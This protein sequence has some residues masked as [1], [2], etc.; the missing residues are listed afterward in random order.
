MKQDIKRLIT[1]TAI[2][3]SSLFLIDALVGYIGEKSLAKLPDYGDELCKSNYRLNRVKTD[4]I[5]VGS[6]RARHNYHTSILADSVNSLLG[7]NFT[8]YNTG[9]GGHFVDCNACT[10][11]SII[12]RHTPKLIIFEVNIQELINKN[13][14]KRIRKYEALYKNNTTVKDYL[15]R[16][17]WIERIRVR[18]NMYRFNSKTIVLI[19]NIL[20]P[21]KADNGYSPLY[22]IMDITNPPKKNDTNRDNYANKYKYSIDNFR[23]ILSLCKDSNIR[24]IIASS[25]LYKQTDNNTLIRSICNE[26]NIPYIELYNT[27]YFNNHPELFYDRKHL[28]NDGATIYTQLFFNE[29]KPYLGGL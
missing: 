25:P 15:D 6:S 18:I 4:V 17:G 24:L 1:N 22:R 5:I 8:F 3:F 13:W 7:K 16:L 26:Y 10:I 27:E 11:E 12:N 2:L 23:R 20:H 14:Q 9:I 28:N 21:R 29:L 19:S